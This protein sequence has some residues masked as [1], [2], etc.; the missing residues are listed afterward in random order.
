MA[1]C[2]RNCVCMKL[3]TFNLLGLDIEESICMLGHAVS[4][5]DTCIIIPSSFVQLTVTCYYSV[6]IHLGSKTSWT[7][8]IAAYFCLHY[9]YYCVYCA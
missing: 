4:V 9:Y 6:H 8:R 1:E 5:R 7:V 3:C 2:V